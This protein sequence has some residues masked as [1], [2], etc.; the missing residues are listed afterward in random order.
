MLKK[1]YL[2]LLATAALVAGA[3]GL[4][5]AFG[6]YSTGARAGDLVK[7]SSKGM[8]FKTGEGELQLGRDSGRAAA[9]TTRSNEENPWR[10]S[11]SGSVY[12]DSQHLIGQPVVIDYRQPYL[13]FHTFGD[14]EYRVKAIAPLDRTT[15]SACGKAD[16]SGWKSSGVR[17]GRVVKASTK[18]LLLKTHEVAVQVGDSGNQFIDM[19]VPDAAI[20]DCA[21]AFLRSGQKARIAYR[22]DFIK[23]PLAQDTTYAVLAIQPEN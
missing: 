7:Y 19:S 4:T 20:F 1:R 21:M 12:A 17:I 13:T 10:F 23:N 22:E 6:N 2:F 3:Y 14:T 9:D 5:F 8:V 16:G 18:G 15:P 11:S